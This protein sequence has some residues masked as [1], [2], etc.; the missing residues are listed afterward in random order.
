MADW[1]RGAALSKMGFD[2]EWDPNCFPRNG[3][4]PGFDYAVL[5]TL[6]DGSM[7]VRNG[8]GVVVLQREG[9]VSIQAE[10]DHLLVD[11]ASWE[12][13]YLPRLQFSEERIP[14]LT[15]FMSEEHD[16]LRGLHCGSLLGTIRNWI[17]VTGVA[18]I[19]ADDED[20]FREIIDTYADLQY[21]CTETILL[22][23]ARFDYGHF[24]EDIC[25]KNGPLINPGVFEELVGPHYRRVTELLK[26]YGITIVSLDCD[27]KIDALIPTWLHNGVNTMFPIEVGTWEA[28]MLPW[29]EQYGKALRGV[30][31]MNKNVLS[32]DRAAVDAEIE[33]L[34][35]LV[36]L[37][38]YIPCPDHRLPPGAEWDNVLYYA[39]RMREVFG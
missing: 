34:R 36:D 18:Y 15:P 23:G 20:L 19:H 10:I 30:G 35:P 13:H 33:R 24:W 37:G 6:P 26:Q 25:F 17:G 29:R 11:R 27:G 14:D 22:S 4:M 38:G 16:E 2:L 31:G 7:K 5:E 32:E 12:A 28:S 1:C 21:R 9:A 8:D 39:E 3:L